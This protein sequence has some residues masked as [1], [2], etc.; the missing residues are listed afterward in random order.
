MNNIYYR[1]TVRTS[2]RSFK[3]NMRYLKLMYPVIG[4]LLIILLFS[5]LGRLWSFFSDMR[6]TSFSNSAVI[7]VAEGMG[8][9]KQSFGSSQF[10]PSMSGDMLLEGDS[11][12]VLPDS[13]VVLE[14]F[15]GLIVRLD[16]G[17]TLTVDKIESKRKQ[18]SI[19]LNVTSGRI[20]VNRPET[21]RNAS[22]LLVT[23]NYL[24]ANSLGT[25]FALDAGLPEMVAVFEGAVLVDIIEP[26][27]DRRSTPLDQINVLADQMIM[28]DNASYEAFRRRETPRV[29]GGIDT[30]FRSN[31]W[32][33]W[34]VQEDLNPTR[35]NAELSGSGSRTLI[36]Q[37]F[38]DSLLVETDIDQTEDTHGKPIVTFPSNNDI[39][40]MNRIEIVGTV[41]SGT[42][43][44]VVTS[45]ES[46]AP[47]PYVL[48]EFRPGQTNF[49]Y[50][51]V[52]DEFDTGNLRLGVNRFEII[53]INEDAI[54][55]EPT[56]L[57]FVLDMGIEAPVINENSSENST[58]VASVDISNLEFNEDLPA[59]T[60][61]TINGEQ[62]TSPFVLR[63]NRAE[64]VADIGSWAQSV[65]VNGYKL[66][67]FE[68][69]SGSFTYILSPG[70]NTLKVG[71]NEVVVYG[72]DA[73]GRRG[74]PATFIV[75]YQP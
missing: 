9:Q 24:R 27:A 8:A 43:A 7:Y 37:D 57:E 2:R 55:S 67:M 38:D 74:M 15:N 52:Y 36:P 5:G 47:T 4:I 70:F 60:L 68:A 6:G 58:E 56:I 75:E 20:W 51:A 49:R 25:V 62:A 29:L 3:G 12:R 41:P 44:V 64:L 17:T 10:L 50:I 13:K 45:F 33:T 46:G 69:G 16:E 71:R 63:T 26:G 53:A 21:I 31:N 61:R 48:R 59:P 22:T 34:N 40:N 14:F 30:E 72:F 39:L 18:E 42:Q 1:P 23:T 73:N 11:L 35:F 65:V 32:I 28:L 66:Q 19:E 54:E